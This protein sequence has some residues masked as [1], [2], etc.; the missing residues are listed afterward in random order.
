[1]LM[2]SILLVR[3]VPF[4]FTL[5]AL[6][7][8]PVSDTQSLAHNHRDSG[9]AVRVRHPAARV[10]KRID[11]LADRLPVPILCL[12][13]ARRLAVAKA[14]ADRGRDP[15]GRDAARRTVRGPCVAGRRG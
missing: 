7:R 13:R 1:M 5:R 9:D 4:R 6:G 10:A 12:A 11:R 14:A 15:A 3:V 2:L 8:R